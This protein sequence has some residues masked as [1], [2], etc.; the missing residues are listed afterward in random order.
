MTS[1]RDNPA[2][3]YGS[4]DPS[5]RTVALSAAVLGTALLS[6]AVATSP[7]QVALPVSATAGAAVMMWSIDRVQRGLTVCLPWTQRC[8]R[9][10]G[11]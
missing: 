9:I 3:E 4:S 11:D 2:N 10:G 1:T 7:V 5:R 6:L 8:R